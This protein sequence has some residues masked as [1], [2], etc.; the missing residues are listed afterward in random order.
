M[1]DMLA[2]HSVRGCAD[3]CGGE[4]NRSITGGEAGAWRDDAEH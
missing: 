1:R 4:P 2:G 3:E